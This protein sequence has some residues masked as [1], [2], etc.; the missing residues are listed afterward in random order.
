MNQMKLKAKNRS[1]F[2]LSDL[3]Q[4]NM[5]IIMKV[6]GKDNEKKEVLT[7]RKNSPTRIRTHGREKTPTFEVNNVTTIPIISSGERGSDV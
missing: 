6:E 3:F 4:Q 1:S 2:A 7:P 5:V